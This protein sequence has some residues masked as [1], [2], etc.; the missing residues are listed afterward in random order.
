MGEKYKPLIGIT[1]GDPAGI[2]PEIIIKALKTEKI[3]E[4]CRPLVIGSVAVL[5][6]AAKAIG[7][8]IHTQIIE[9]PAEAEYHL[10]TINVIETDT[11]DLSSLEWGKEQALGGQIAMDSIYKSIEM[12]MNGEVDAVTTAPINKVAIKMVGVK[13]AG[14][15][16]IYLDKTGSDYVLTMFDCFNMRVFHLSRHMSLRNA[17]DYATKE[18]ILADI[19]R[20]DFQLKKIGIENPKI[21]VAGINPHCGEGGLFGDEEIKEVIPAILA[22]Q[23]QGINAIG[24][25][26]PDTLFSRGKK[27]EFDAILAMYH[28]QGHIP[29]KTLDLEKSV[30]MTLGLPFIRGSVDH[31]TAFDIAGKGIAT[32]TSMVAAIESTIRYAAAMHHAETK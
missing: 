2:G 7:E 6:R 13:Q 22:A 17:I 20:I 27:G 16:E 30:S 29:C 3:Y 10:G 24:P 14:H 5:E 9:K 26:S 32:N 19:Q 23:E 12:G 11:Y 15:T 28:D 4:D 21:A 25:I 18:H 1:I 31:G 8:T